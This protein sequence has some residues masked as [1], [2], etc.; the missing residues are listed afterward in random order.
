M[1]RK[2]PTGDDHPNRG[3]HTQC[4]VDHG[5]R[6][7]PDHCTR[8]CAW[9]CPDASQPGYVAPGKERPQPLGYRENRLR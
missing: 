3:P 6:G 1:T 5:G 4:L 2:P 8:G 7:V 9:P